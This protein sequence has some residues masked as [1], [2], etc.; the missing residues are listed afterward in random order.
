MTTREIATAIEEWVVELI[1]AL[2]GHSYD[3]HAS[4]KSHTLPDVAVEIDEMQT[5]DSPRDVGMDDILVAP[6]GWEQVVFRSWT[7]RVLLM[8]DENPPSAAEATLNEYSDTLHD[9]VLNDR[10]LGQRVPWT[11][12]RIRSDMTPPFVIFDDDTRGRLVTIEM[13]VGDAIPYED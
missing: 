3:Y 13:L 1:P 7:V 8:V 10:T 4:E 12:R 5:G 9:G 2:D 6:S 11:S